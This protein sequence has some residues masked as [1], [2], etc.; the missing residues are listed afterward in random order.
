MPRKAKSLTSI[1]HGIMEIVSDFDKRTYR[2]IYTVKIGIKIYVLHCFQKKSKHGIAT[3]KFEIDMIKQRLL[4][5]K[6]IDNSREI[7]Y[8]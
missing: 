6:Q 1:S 3:P 4:Q 8:D 2:A 7:K 5:A